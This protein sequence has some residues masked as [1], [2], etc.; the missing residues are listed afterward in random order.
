MAQCLNPA[1][2]RHGFRQRCSTRKCIGLTFFIATLTRTRPTWSTPN[3]I[4][5]VQPKQPWGFIFCHHSSSTDWGYPRNPRIVIQIGSYDGQAPLWTKGVRSTR[6][7]HRVHQESV[8]FGGISG[9][10]QSS[11]GEAASWA[12]VHLDLSCVMGSQATPP[13]WQAQ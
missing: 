11:G 6:L 4:S 7:S 8:A 10:F 12:V 9:H 5:G 2:P 1:Q 3:P 13:P